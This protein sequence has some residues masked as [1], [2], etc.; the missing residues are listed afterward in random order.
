MKI[1]TKGFLIVIISLTFI[2]SFYA[3]ETSPRLIILKPGETIQWSDKAK[4]YYEP[5]IGGYSYTLK[6]GGKVEVTGASLKMPILGKT[7]NIASS[8]NDFVVSEDVIEMSLTY[9]RT[10]YICYSMIETLVQLKTYSPEKYKYR[11]LYCSPL[12][13]PLL[14]ESFVHFPQ[15]IL[16]QSYLAFCNQ[17]LNAN[18]SH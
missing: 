6:G 8:A 2:T 12:I 14:R 3:Q 10:D 11:N 9:K 1:T 18:N 5:K 13:K 16:A 4:N 17:W 7:S 15:T